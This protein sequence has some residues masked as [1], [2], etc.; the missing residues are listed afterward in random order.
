MSDETNETQPDELTLL[1]ARADQMGIPYKGNIGIETL[2]GK[3][4]AEMSGK[5]SVSEPEEESSK[6]E[7]GKAPR[8][9]TEAERQ[10]EVR[11][12]LTREKMKLVRVRISNLNPAK[13]DLHG[14]IITVRNKFIGTVRRM[15]PFGEAT[16]G[17]YHIEQI[18]Y[19]DL[20]SRRFQQIRTKRVN[21]QIQHEARLV[22]EYSIEVMEPLTEKERE[23]LAHRQ[24][25][26]ER[27]AGQ[28]G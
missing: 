16:D 8:K 27:L 1:K 10:Q 26:A 18:I 11:D 20:K 2:K 5:A 24:Q 19:D 7:E 17:G 25:A 13:N 21:G 28:D 23:D 3:I 12:R 14:E 22:P 15:I 6:D 9:P 4:E